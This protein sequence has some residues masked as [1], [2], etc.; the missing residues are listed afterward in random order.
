MGCKDHLV[1]ECPSELMIRGHDGV[2]DVDPFAMCNKI[3][4]FHFCIIFCHSA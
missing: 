1:D 2:V 3:L 4:N